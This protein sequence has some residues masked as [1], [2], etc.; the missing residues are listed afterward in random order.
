MNNTLPNSSLASSISSAPTPTPPQKRTI[1]ANLKSTTDSCDDVLRKIEKE[2]G[3]QI[4]RP[5]L[6]RWI[7]LFEK[8]G[9]IQKSIE[10]CLLSFLF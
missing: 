3:F 8:R 4:S 7:A 2:G 6:N 9:Q 1:L 5:D 10:V